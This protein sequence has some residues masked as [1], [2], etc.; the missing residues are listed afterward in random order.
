MA[1]EELTLCNKYTS[2]K[3]FDKNGESVKTSSPMTT[4]EALKHFNATGVI[5][6]N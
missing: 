5:G 1:K 6:I 2:W 3:V 4:D